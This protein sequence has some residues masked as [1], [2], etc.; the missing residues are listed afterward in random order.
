MTQ[1][2]SV[3]DALYSADSVSKV[4]SAQSTF[5][6]EVVVYEVT[7]CVGAT[8]RVAEKFC[9]P[10]LLAQVVVECGSCGGRFYAAPGTSPHLCN[11]CEQ[12]GAA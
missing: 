11:G 9:I 6:A 4:A 3:E 2:A 7:S 5:G 10:T 1:F 8:V 12:G